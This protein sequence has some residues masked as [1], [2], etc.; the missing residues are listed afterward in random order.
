[1]HPECLLFLVYFK[2]NI[3]LGDLE[4]FPALASQPLYKV[5]P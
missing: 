4:S 2:R 3:M 1:M 5:F